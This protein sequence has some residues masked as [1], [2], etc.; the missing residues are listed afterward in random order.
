VVSASRDCTL[1]VWDAGSGKQLSSVYTY[2]SLACMAADWASQTVATGLRSSIF[3]HFQGTFR[4]TF[5][6]HAGNIQGTS[7]DHPRHIQGT[8]RAQS[9]HIQGTFGE[10][11]GHIQ[12]TFRERSW[13]SFVVWR[14][15]VIG[16]A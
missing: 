10:H 3:C 14:W 16:G 12:V 15:R 13:M 8:F 1:R 7:R 9:G 11:S 2:D 4:G 6:A 5:R